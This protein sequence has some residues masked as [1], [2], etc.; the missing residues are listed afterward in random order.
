[1]YTTRLPSARSTRGRA[2]HFL[3]DNAPCHVARKTKG[4]IED[5]ITLL[6]LP[7]CSPDLN[8]IENVWHWM[9][10]KTKGRHWRKEELRERLETLWESVPSTLIDDLVASMPARCAAI[11]KSRGRHTKY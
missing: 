7:P 9:K 4:F 8:V 10:L 3:Q 2:L 11:V 1:M 5:R 6:Q